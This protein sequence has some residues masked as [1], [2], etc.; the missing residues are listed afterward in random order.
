MA[1]K[2]VNTVQGHAISRAEE[3]TTDKYAPDTL[4]RYHTTLA[5]IDGLVADGCFTQ[6]D[7]RKAYTIIKAPNIDTREEKPWT[8][9]YHSLLF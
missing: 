4:M 3:S 7:K 8:E 6:A 2:I 9:P 5:L 1:K